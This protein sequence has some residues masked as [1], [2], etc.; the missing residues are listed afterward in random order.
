M[1][2]GVAMAGLVDEPAESID[3]VHDEVD[4]LGAVELTQR[5]R[6]LDHAHL[7]YLRGVK[8]PI[9]VKIGPIF[10]ENFD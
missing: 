10:Q 3:F 1:H 2:R 7:D 4:A 9:G 8:N 6:Q 5:T